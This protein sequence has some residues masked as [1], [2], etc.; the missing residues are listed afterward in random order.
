MLWFELIIFLAIIVIGARIGG[1]AMGTMAG[2]GL[3]IFIFVFKLP[4]GSPPI[5]VLGMILA[6]ITAL[7]TM[8]AAGG[9]DFLVGVAEKIMRKRPQNITL[10]APLVTYILV[11]ASGTQ[12]V[13]YALLPII[14]EISRKSGIR[15]ERPMAMT[16][17]AA[18]QGLVSSPIS[19]STVA[20]I[21]I[22]SVMGVSLPQMMV[23][24]IPST[25]IAVVI[26]SITVL[27]K[28]K[29]LVNDPIYQ[30]RLKDGK[31]IALEATK[32]PDKK[33]LNNAKGSTYMFFFAIIMI[34]I[35]GMFPELRPTY[36]WIV[37]GEL[38]KDQIGMGPAIM[39][40]MLA[41][42]GIIMIVF[43]AKA[44]KAVGGSI[45]KSGVVALISIL[46]IAW[47]GSSFF[48]G[49]RFVIVESISQAIEGYQWVFGFGLF[50]LSIMLF[51]QAATVVTLMP[52]GLALGLDAELLIAL[53]PAVNGYFVLPT[54]GTVLAAISFD[55]TGT[56]KIGNRLVNHSFMLPGLVTTFSAV[57]IALLITYIA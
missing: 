10:V 4:V 22:L 47:L 51:S 53:Y 36:E 20:M 37:D 24:I 1:I 49:N 21:G 15:P 25:L 5:I 3:V 46:G 57:I 23:V 55:Q 6:V 27:K 41:I 50:T 48:E 40:I 19:A 33:T 16:V 14:S 34:V 42:G 43:K 56:T 32:T 29:E 9:L 52:V 11:L 30:Q 2:I 39:I 12:H 35:I 18:M 7:S 28:G 54:Y 17:I 31:I 26:G 13:I 44:G 45:M 8:E 38:T